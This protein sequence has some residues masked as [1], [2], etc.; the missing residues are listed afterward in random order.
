MATGPNPFS[1]STTRNLL[2]HVFSPKIVSA[3][4]GYVVKLDMINIDNITI[5]GTI[6]GFT[7]GSAGTTGPQGSTGPRGATG[8][9]GPRGFIGLRGTT[10]PIGPTGIQGPIGD[11]GPTG[12]QGPTGDTGPTGTMGSQGPTGYTGDTGPTGPMGTMGATGPTGL[13]GPVGLQG[14]T[15]PPLSVSTQSVTYNFP[16]TL[17]TTGYTVLWS[18]PVSDTIGTMSTGGSWTATSPGIYSISVYAKITSIANPIYQPVALEGSLNQFDGSTSYIIAPEI[19]LAVAGVSDTTKS[20]ITS[21]VIY[22]TSSSSISFKIDSVVG[23]FT[24]NTCEFAASMY[25]R[26]LSP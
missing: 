21:P 23:P 9:T 3:T 10:G 4:G 16:Q 6:N 18:L 24:S 15:G 11:T 5:S 14:P 20:G 25:I 7:G 2:D 17:V 22:L 1:I 8:P 26:Y 12:I 13:Q 19:S